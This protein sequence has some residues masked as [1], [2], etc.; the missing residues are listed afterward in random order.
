MMVIIENGVWY[1][2][3]INKDNMASS[4]SLDN[5]DSANLV[6]KIHFLY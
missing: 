3:V 2:A 1:K 6:F 5:L 4:Y